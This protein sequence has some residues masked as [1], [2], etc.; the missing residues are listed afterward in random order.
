MSGMRIGNL[1]IFPKPT[2]REMLALVSFII[3]MAS[4]FLLILGALLIFKF[5]GA[6]FAG[7]ENSVGFLFDLLA[8]LII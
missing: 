8:N 7:L 5:K 6:V 4:P 2:K 1:E 3:F